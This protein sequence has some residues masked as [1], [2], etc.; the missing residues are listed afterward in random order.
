QGEEKAMESHV[1]VQYFRG[2]NPVG[3]PII[4]NSVSEH[5]DITD[6]DF[7]DYV[8]WAKDAFEITKDIYGAWNP[9]AGTT[10]TK[11]FFNWFGVIGDIGT[12]LKDVFHGKN[13]AAKSVGRLMLLA[14]G[15]MPWEGPAVDEARIKF[16]A[17]SEDDLTTSFGSVTPE[18]KLIDLGEIRYDRNEIH[19]Y[20]KSYRIPLRDTPRGPYFFSFGSGDEGREFNIGVA[21]FLTVGIAQHRHSGFL[22]QSSIGNLGDLKLLAPNP[23]GGLMYYWRTP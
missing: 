19:F 13:R 18:G 20:E 22:I 8:T 4:V 5:P 6:F 17:S 21:S 11:S 16:Q 12:A 14:P 10:T 3:P 15:A 9:P 23:T 1:E 2:G 7:A